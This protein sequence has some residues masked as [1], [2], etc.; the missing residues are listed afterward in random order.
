MS[1]RQ[2]LKGMDSTWYIY[3]QSSSLKSRK[4]ICRYNVSG[5]YEHWNNSGPKQTG[6]W[7]VY[8]SRSES[9]TKLSKLSLVLW[10]HIGF[11]SPNPGEKNKKRMRALTCFHASQLTVT[12]AHM[13]KTVTY[14]ACHTQESSGHISSKHSLPLIFPPKGLTMT[15][16][17][18]ETKD[19]QQR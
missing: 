15:R 18:K 13:Q 11:P 14:A 4:R 9:K 7:I 17:L 3:Q 8:P 16:T 12:Y 5:F 1:Y 2:W 6:L 19:K 10:W